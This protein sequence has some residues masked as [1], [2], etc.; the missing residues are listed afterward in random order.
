MHCTGALETDAHIFSD[1]HKARAVWSC[2]GVSVHGDLVQRPWDIGVAIPHPGAI[3]IDIVLL[4]LWHLWKSRNTMIFDQADST[5][6][7]TILRAIR[8]LDAWSSRYKKHSS[9]LQDWRLW[10]QLC[11]SS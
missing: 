5:P 11:T 8:D 6:L 3:R 2:L 10:L 4:I 1:C 9:A 7:D